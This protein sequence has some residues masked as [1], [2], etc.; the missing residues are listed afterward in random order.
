MTSVI[1]LDEWRSKADFLSAQKSPSPQSIN[2]EQIGLELTDLEPSTATAIGLYITLDRAWRQPFKV[3]SR[4]AREGALLVGIAATEGWITNSVGDDGWGD[5]WLITELG[6]EMKGELDNV[7]QE[8][9][10]EPT[11]T[12]D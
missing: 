9:F 2:W 1:S 4:F 12:T 5:K 3:G 10:E 8:I 7:L 11:D 6:I